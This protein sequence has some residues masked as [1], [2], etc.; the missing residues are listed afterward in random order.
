[1]VNEE[2]A[3]IKPAQVLSFTGSFIPMSSSRNRGIIGADRAN[4]IMPNVTAIKS[5]VKLLVQ[6]LIYSKKYISLKTFMPPVCR[7]LIKI[8]QNYIKIF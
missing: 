7:E 1:M 3:W 4:P 5:A 2:L 8:L 6:D